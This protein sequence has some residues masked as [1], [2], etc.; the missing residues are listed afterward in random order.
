MGD[1]YVIMLVI[2]VFL[3]VL[4]LVVGVSND[5]VNFLNSA[6]GSKAISIKSIMWIASIGIA[7]GAL[8][9]SGMMEVARKGIFVPGQFYFDEI[10]FIF[11]AV[12]ITDIILLDVF[13]S[14]GMPTSTTVSIVFELLGAAVA[15][16]IIKIYKSDTLSFADL[17]TFINSDKAIQIIVG[18]LLSVFIAFSIGALVQY[19]SRMIYSFEIKKNNVLINSIFGGLAITSITYFVIIKGM[20]GTEIYSDIKSVINDNTFIVLSIGTMFWGLV[21]AALIRFFKIDILKFIIGIGT[22][23]LAMA[24]AGN[25]LVNFIGVPIAAWNSFEV[26]QASGLAANEFSMGVLAKKVPSNTFILLIAGVVMVITLWFSKKA[27]TVIE[28]G[29]NLSR[30]GEGHEKF[31]PNSLSRAVVRY[32]MILNQGFITVLPKSVI[33]VIEK[34][35]KEP[36]RDLLQISTEDRPAFDLLRASI[37]IVV[38]GILIAIGTSSKIA[39]VY[40]VCHFYGSHGYFFGGSSLGKRKCCL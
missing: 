34:R 9:S 8:S 27:K 38:A 7:F 3:A 4:D 37:N 18:I 28:T 5:A 40:N 16:A 25:D 30:Q 22:F 13:N 6:I 17:S 24:F 10:M 1:F 33:S 20:K 14:F 31:K 2:L 12:M 29:I 11:L 32:S 19:V 39:F 15:T 23:S 35:F 21:S 26:W 36:H